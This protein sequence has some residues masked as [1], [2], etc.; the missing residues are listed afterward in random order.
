MKKSTLI[1]FCSCGILLG[2]I[3]EL[4]AK[5]TVIQRRLV[6]PE[7][8]EEFISRETTFWSEVAQKAVDDGKMAQWSLWQKVDGID[9]DED[10]N[11]IFINSFME[12]NDL[13]HIN[14]I[15]DYTSVFPN[16]KPEQVSTSHLSTVKDMLFYEQIAFSFKSRP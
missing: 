9:I 6:Q 5:V 16:K 15:W 7:N 12:P 2:S 8:I 10:H 14:E 3:F 11:F 13:D 1:Y 4:S